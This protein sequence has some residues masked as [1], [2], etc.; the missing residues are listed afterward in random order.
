MNPGAAAQDNLVAMTCRYGSG[1]RSGDSYL[2]EL[3]GAGDREGDL[4]GIAR[5][6]ACRHRHRLRPGLDQAVGQSTERDH[7][8]TGGNA[9]QVDGRAAPYG[10]WSLRPTSP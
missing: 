10:N 8:V 2:A 9:V 4:G 3:L 7:M 1:S 5:Q 6:G